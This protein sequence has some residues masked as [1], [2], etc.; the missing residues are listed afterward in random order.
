MSTKEFRMNTEELLCPCSPSTVSRVLQGYPDF[1]VEEI[2][3]LIEHASSTF[4]HGIAKCMVMAAET[5]Q[6][7]LASKMGA[8]M[9]QCVFRGTNS[10]SNIKLFYQMQQIVQRVMNGPERET[11][12]S[13]ARE[14][15]TVIKIHHRSLVA[16][17]SVPDV[18]PEY[19]SLVSQVLQPSNNL[20]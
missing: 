2:G 14:P 10:N 6:R 17:V 3:S 13:I 11:T 8:L 16:E 18:N 20:L 12:W 19:E 4:D 7:D 15:N 1:S 9:K 5:A